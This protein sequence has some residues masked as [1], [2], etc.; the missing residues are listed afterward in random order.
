MSLLNDDDDDD[1]DGVLCDSRPVQLNC[2]NCQCF[3]R[4]FMHVAVT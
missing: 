2:T 3:A 1:D 4:L